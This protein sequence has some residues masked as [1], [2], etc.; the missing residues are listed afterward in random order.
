[1]LRRRRRG[2]R[3]D[4]LIEVT[5][6]GSSGRCSPWKGRQRGLCGLA[7]EHSRK[8]EERREIG[9]RDCGW[10]TSRH[11]RTTKPGASIQRGF[12]MREGRQAAWQW[13]FWKSRREPAI[14]GDMSQAE[15]NGASDPVLAHGP[16]MFVRKAS[17]AKKANGRSC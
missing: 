10:P 15:A 2:W 1:M 3:W 5:D 6:V 8:M 7:Q 14:N 16:I 13:Q 17:G 4:G 9:G 11:P 12:S